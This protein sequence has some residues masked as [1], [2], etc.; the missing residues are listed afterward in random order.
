L[1]RGDL[2][3]SFLFLFLFLFLFRTNAESDW[4]ELNKILRL[5]RAAY[6]LVWSAKWCAASGNEIRTRSSAVGL[7]NGLR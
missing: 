4:S 5:A 1:Q 6:R 3:R 7:Q 2:A